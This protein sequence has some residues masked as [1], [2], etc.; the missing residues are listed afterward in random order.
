VDDEQLV[1]SQREAARFLDM[2]PSS[3]LHWRRSGKIGPAP[4]TLKELLAV[5][6]RADAPP[7]RRGVKAVHG[8]RSR[9]GAGCNCPDCRAASAAIQKE[10]ERVEAKRQFTPEMRTA[11]LDL[12]AQGV[13]FKQALGRIGVRAHQVW[14]R[15]HSDPGWGA[16]LQ[17]IID[18]AR[19]ADIN[20]GRQAGYRQGCRCSE[21]RAAR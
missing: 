3:T 20:H 2:R 13:P 18:R 16:Q 17:A 7:R 15:A 8:T 5:K 12:L 11:L 1:R 4:W 21:F 9:V 19:A 6:H 14:G 10:R